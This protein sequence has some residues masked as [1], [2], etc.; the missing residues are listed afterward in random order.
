MAENTL[1]AQGTDWVLH[2]SEFIFSSSFPP[3]PQVL[4]KKKQA[5]RGQAFN[6]YIFH[7]LFYQQRMKNPKGQ[8]QLANQW[9]IIADFR[10]HAGEK[11][12]EAP[13]ALGE[14]DLNLGL[15]LRN[16][17]PLCLETSL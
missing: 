9:G 8:K 7:W 4:Q 13:A 11:D 6:G 5:S 12:A 2:L 15:V 16:V 17:P 1:S 10:F 14:R 3:P